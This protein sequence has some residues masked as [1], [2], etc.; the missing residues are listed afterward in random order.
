MDKKKKKPFI[1][2]AIIV[3][4]VLLVILA[5]LFFGEKEQ[6]LRPG[7]YTFWTAGTTVHGSARR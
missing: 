5:Y 2:V 1:V 7:R 6:K 4:I 3:L